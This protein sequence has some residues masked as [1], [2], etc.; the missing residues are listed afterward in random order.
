MK[1]NP[2]TLLSPEGK[3]GVN[4]W[5][6]ILLSVWL[7]C[8]L[9]NQVNSNIRNETKD[10]NN[11]RIDKAQDE[12]EIWKVAKEITSPSGNPV[13]CSLK[14]DGKLIDDPLQVATIFNDYFVDKIMALK[15]LAQKMRKSNTLWAK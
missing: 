4:Y 11:N 15:F 14:S 10:F 2:K 1:A 3:S 7:L 6:Y 12:N 5:L 13:N 8:K 9:R